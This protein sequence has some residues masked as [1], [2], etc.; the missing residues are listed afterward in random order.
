MQDI[1][2]P[3]QTAFPASELTAL[4]KLRASFPPLPQPSVGR[5]LLSHPIT[6]LLQVYAEILSCAPR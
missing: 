6:H 2:T 5:D 4:A 3:E 1:D